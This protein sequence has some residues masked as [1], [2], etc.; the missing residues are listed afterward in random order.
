MTEAIDPTEGRVYGGASNLIHIPDG[1]RKRFGEELANALDWQ[2]RRRAY[3]TG[4]R[5]QQQAYGSD[6]SVIRAAPDAQPLCPGC[7]MV[8]IVAMAVTLAERNGQSVT[9]LGNSLSA[10][11]ADLAKN[12]SGQRNME[13][14]DV[15]LDP[16]PPTETELEVQWTRAVYAGFPL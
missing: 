10:A 14:I 1:E 16:E 11:F 9:E 13:W 8:A 4:A 5:T 2:M 3:A 7:Y 15:Q 6:G 12:G